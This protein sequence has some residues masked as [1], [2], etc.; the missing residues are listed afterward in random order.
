MAQTQIK[1]S[2]KQPTL[3]MLE[4]IF[5]GLIVL[6]L[7]VAGYLTWTH[8]A[9][10]PVICTP[11]GGCD[12]VNKS[13]YAYFPPS[14][15]VPVALVGLVGYIAIAGM[16]FMR[17]QNPTLRSKLDMGL[18]IATLVGV[19]FSGYLTAMELFVIHAICWWCVTSA[20]VITVMFG[21]TVVKLWNGAP[22]Y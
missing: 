12:T 10:A 14:W 13:A 6:G 9:D 20:V 16:W 5:L 17:W 2:V 8:F 3:P 7:I 21:I 1:A 15:G 18:F 19:I 11:G 4:K 22:D